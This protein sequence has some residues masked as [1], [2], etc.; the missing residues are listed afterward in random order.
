MPSIVVMGTYTEQGV[1][2]IK[3]LPERLA[4]SRE[5]IQGA[6]GRLIFFYLTMGEYD[7]VAVTEVPDAETGARI[8]LGLAQQGN[9]RTKSMYA[10]TEEES[11]ALVAGLP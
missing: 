4:A 3:D 9:I 7:F 10:F 6:G 8:A 11:A 2:A 5:A 1:K